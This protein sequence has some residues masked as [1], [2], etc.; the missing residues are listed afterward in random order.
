M[1]EGSLGGQK[2][3]KALD[4]TSWEAASELLMTCEARGTLS[5]RV[6]TVPDAVA[7][8]MEDTATRAPSFRRRFPQ[9]ADR[10]REGKQRD[11]DED[12]ITGIS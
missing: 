7:K 4:L 9:G 8:F 2:L 10:R 3:R 5:G 12:M 6:I 1:A 11:R